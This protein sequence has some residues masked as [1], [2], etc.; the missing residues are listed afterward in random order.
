MIE[1]NIKILE[2]GNNLELPSYATEGS[3]GVDLKA[4]IDG[5]IVIHPLERLLISTGICISLPMGYEAQI[6]PRSGLALKNGIT[7]LNSPGTIDSDYRGELKVLLINLGKDDFLIEKGMRIAQ[8]IIQK[9]EKL[10]WRVVQSLDE[11]S[12]AEGGY[13]ST[14]FK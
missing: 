5:S 8:L 6:R 10:V 12:R 13:G 3:A 4:A 2:S 11:T 1:V 7:V 14:G 9:Y